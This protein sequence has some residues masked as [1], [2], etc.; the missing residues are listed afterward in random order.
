MLVVLQSARFGIGGLVFLCMVGG[1]G[2]ASS[3][4]GN[5]N[6]LCMDRLYT[7]SH[8][9]E[10]LVAE[11]ACSSAA[12][13]SNGA[14]RSILGCE[15]SLRACQQ[16]CLDRLGSL[17]L[18]VNS[19]K[20]ICTVQDQLM[21]QYSGKP[22]VVVNFR[23][24]EATG[25]N[26]PQ[27]LPSLLAGPASI[28]SF[29]YM[30]DYQRCIQGD[31]MQYCLV[32]GARQLGS[33]KISGLLGLCRPAECSQ[34]E[35]KG[36]IAP[37]AL[38]L[39]LSDYGVECHKAGD[40]LPR[41]EWSGGKIAALILF[42]LLLLLMVIGTSL[43]L[44]KLWRVPELASEAPART[45]GSRPRLMSRASR[46]IKDIVGAWSLVRNIAS[47]AKTRPHRADEGAHLVA[48]DGLR[49]VSTLW[50]I[51]GHTVIW[52]LLSVQ[53][54]NAGMILPPLGRLTKVWFQIVPGGYFAV[55][56]F[57]WLS[58]FLGARTLHAKVRRNPRLVSL[59]GFSFGLYPLGLFSRWLRL[60][61]VYAFLLIFTQT[62][63]RELG[64]GALLWNARM[65]GIGGIGCAS[66]I[67]ND[68]CKSYWWASL[69]YINNQVPAGGM[70]MAWTWYLA[71]DMQMFVVLPFIVLLRERVGRTTGWV[72]LASML[73]ASYVANA[74][75]IWR[76]NLV[77][78][79]VLGN[80]GGKFMQ[81]VYEVS[82]MRVQPYLI[83][84][85]CAW[86]IQALPVRERSEPAG[87]NS[88]SDGHHAGVQTS[89]E[90]MELERSAAE[91]GGLATLPGGSLRAPHA[92]R[93][94]ES[95]QLA[96]E[97][98]LRDPEEPEPIGQ[99]RT[100][101]SWQLAPEPLLRD[102]EEPEP[103]W[104]RR[105]FSLLGVAVLLQVL[106][107]AAM[108]FVV[109]IPVTRYRCSSVQTCADVD[110]SP[111]SKVGNVLYGTFN[112]TVWALGLGC[113]MTLCFVQAPGTWWINTF[114]GAE[115]WQ[116]PAKLTYSAYLLHPLVIVFFY[117]Q[118]E[119][120]LQYLDTTLLSDFLAFLVIVF[121]GAFILWLLVEKPGA[122]LTAKFFGSLEGRREGAG[123][124]A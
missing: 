99:R 65:P 91:V 76:E 28:P 4:D 10:Q 32:D 39:G 73:V 96:P 71:C 29:S 38:Q 111:W 101:G 114:L 85:G 12:I 27:L 66:S 116:W 19:T 55:D 108:C 106:S 58:G 97:P 17:G 50:V 40:P 87:L 75:V 102:P 1:L 86:L 36:S 3:T 82:W 51:L 72:S 31:M 78:D 67:D 11:V 121:L 59:S 68:T 81:H 22:E 94:W 47:F 61:F 9:N 48:L 109:F 113:L 89:K 63:Y 44:Q 105:K 104:Q 83:G 60:S 43:E 119:H 25:L 54:E 112:H 70:C 52:P 8:C 37:M 107:F 5:E 46:T 124:G 95:R 88:K 122:N 120:A 84:V 6:G 92:E 115:F 30:G 100:S 74:W 123:G 13:L 57:F 103:I 15:G 23:R 35:I 24:D 53:Y 41:V 98:L 77:T 45:S 2:H 64:R 42:V 118:N 33:L 80:I 79:P 90:T 21:S 7:L 93:P 26:K 16:T 56:T 110:T 62:W 20:P 117:C 18:P 69:L 49:V 34:G 14:A